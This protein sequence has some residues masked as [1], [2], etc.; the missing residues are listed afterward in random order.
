MVPTAS[1][2]HITRHFHFEAVPPFL[3][4]IGLLNLT[5]LL[6]WVSLSVPRGLSTPYLRL[7]RRH[8]DRMARSGLSDGR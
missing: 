4:F 5:W 1:A 3:N 7:R 8:C 6:L 2:Y